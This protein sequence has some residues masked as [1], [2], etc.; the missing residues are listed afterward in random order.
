MRI[1]TLNRPESFNA[2]N[3]DLKKGLAE[4]LI[5]IA[6]DDSVRTVILTGAGKAFC[7][8]G[9]LKWVWTHPQGQ[10]AA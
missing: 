10:A 6:Q 8:G 4:H 2:L 7:P 5:Q 9:D 3:P 1:L